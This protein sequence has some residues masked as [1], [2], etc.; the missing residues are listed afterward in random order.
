MKVGFIAILGRPNVGKSTL[1][2]A[3]LSKKVSIVTPKAQTTRD[4]IMGILTEKDYQMVFVDTPGIHRGDLRLDKAMRRSAFDSAKGVN[5]ILYL[6]DASS[7]SL[8]A[9]LRIAGSLDK[10]SPLIFVLNKI[11]LVR[12]EVGQEIKQTLAAS[13]PDSPIIEASLIENFGLRQIKDAVLPTLEE[14]EPYYPEDWVTDKDRAYQAK[15]VIREQMLL[16]YRQ[17]IPH[18]AAV[19]IDSIEE[20]EGKLYLKAT[21]YVSREAHKGI[22]IGK[23]GEAIRSL[24]L[25]STKELA[26][27]WHKEIAALNMQ[28]VCDPS[29]RDDPKKL[30]LLGYG[31]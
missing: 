3:L 20:K 4:A 23:G 25:S 5:A 18:Q 21:I 31:E 7:R 10:D 13:F 17:E 29:W 6:I 11:D 19:S 26:R 1:L 14:G 30:S 16:L 28:V 2:N 27:M 22:V 15:E 12:P 8:D 9:D 24:R